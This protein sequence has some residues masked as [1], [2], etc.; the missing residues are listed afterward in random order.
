MQNA[1]SDKIRVKTEIAVPKQINI[2][3]TDL[4]A[5]LGNL[6]DNALDA[7]YDVPEDRRSLTI[8]VVFSQERLIVRT[9]NPY[10]GDVLCKDG[11]IVSAKH[12]SKHHGYGLNNI[13]KAVNKYKGYID[14]DYT[15]N[16]FTVDI[17]MYI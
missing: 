11:K 4:V 3:T 5:I 10:I 12:S 1:Q 8:K 7:L 15:G 9:S 17:L 6:I 2:E 13:A 14:I 16:I